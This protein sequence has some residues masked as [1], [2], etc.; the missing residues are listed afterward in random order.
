MSRENV[1][2]VR[3]GFDAL[4]RG[5]W[6]ALIEVLDPDVEW[7]T[8]GQF[9]EGGA[10][11]GHDGVREFLTTLGGEFDDFRAEAERITDADD[12][13]V[14]ETRG[15]GVGKRSGARVEIEFTILVNLTEGRV[16][17]LRNFMDRGEALEAAGLRE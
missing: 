4:S 5:D 13:V 7:R 8:T 15:S 1:E 10:Y 2:V 11:R 9:V 16:T 17:R 6:D 3:A 12:V 14:V